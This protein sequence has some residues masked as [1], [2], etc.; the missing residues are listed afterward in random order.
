ME[1]SLT[2]DQHP[3]SSA[4][5]SPEGTPWAL[6]PTV[7]P[8]HLLSPG[9]VLFLPG[10]RYLKFLRVCV[11]FTVSYVPKKCNQVLV[12]RVHQELS[13]EVGKCVNGHLDG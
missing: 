3:S 6:S 7:T 5:Q 10:T 8:G 13:I 11:M 4:R 2:R 9:L 12:P 1:D